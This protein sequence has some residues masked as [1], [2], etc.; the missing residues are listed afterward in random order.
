[1]LDVCR[2]VNTHILDDTQAVAEAL[3]KGAVAEEEEDSETVIVVAAAVLVVA[4][5]TGTPAEIGATKV[6][7][8]RSFFASAPVRKPFL[9]RI[10]MCVYCWYNL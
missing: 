2:V 9:G 7:R 10:W 8:L 5:E 1:M 3:E 4:V 6:R